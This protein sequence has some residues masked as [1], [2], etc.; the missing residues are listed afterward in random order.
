[1]RASM[2]CTTSGLPRALEILNSDD[3]V[4]NTIQITQLMKVTKTRLPCMK[5]DLLS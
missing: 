3:D 2:N 4:K 5:Q 1:M